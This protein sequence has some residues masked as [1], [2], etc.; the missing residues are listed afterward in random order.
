MTKLNLSALKAVSGGTKAP[1]CKP[2][3]VCKP[4]KSADCS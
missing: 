3:P 2:A 4:A 1:E